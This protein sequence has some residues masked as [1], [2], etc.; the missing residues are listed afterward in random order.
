[1]SPVLENFA[2]EP[3]TTSAPL[4]LEPPQ[5]TVTGNLVVS[6]PDIAL[7]DG[8]LNRVGVLVDHLN[9]VLEAHGDDVTP[10][11]G[12][13]VQLEGK[14]VEL[15]TLRWDHDSAWLPRFTAVAPGGL[16][17]GRYIAPLDC[18]G[19]E[20][21]LA[22]Q[23]RY[24]NT[25]ADDVRVNLGWAGR[26]IGTQLSHF[27]A[28]PLRA[29]VIA[30]HDSW[31]GSTVLSLRTET[32]LLA[33]GLRG[34]SATP[35]QLG[36]DGAWQALREESVPPS[37]EMVVDLFIA[38]APEPDGASSGA[39]HL[40][41]RGF[42][43]L[44]QETVSW[45][46]EHALPINDDRLNASI[47]RHLFFNYFFAQGD[48]LDSGRPVI[49]TSRS[50]HYYVSAAFWSRDAFWW[51]FPALVL[52]D[53]VRARSVLL[54]CLRTC[55][56]RLPD[57]AL[58]LN[59][60]RMY[61]GFELDQAAAPVLAVWRY[62]RDSGDKT[63]CDEA[64]VSRLLRGFSGTIAPW[65]SEELELYATFLL[66][67]DDPTEYPYVTTCNAMVA[68]ALD[69]VAELSG[70]GVDAPERE[71]A[72]RVR[73]AIRERL[74]VESCGADQWAWAC[75]ARGVHELRDEPPLGL[76]LLSYLGLCGNDDPTYLATVR[77][78]TERNPF[79][80][81]GPHGGAGAPH[82]PYPSG[83]DLA[84]RLL[85]D[86]RDERGPL[87]ELCS[88]P[89]DH[90]LGCESWDSHTGK[91]RTGAAMASMSGLLAWT[92]WARI[93]GH[94]HWRQPLG[95]HSVVDPKHS[96]SEKPQ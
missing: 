46:D 69:A 26:W 68:A 84:S 10:F 64:D 51:T 24:R 80:F 37:E 72:E 66:P 18:Y 78:T 23:L 56:P 49:T 76:R 60:T 54:E 95:R 92:A 6:A 75:D 79:Y 63:I 73:F 14:A 38:V 65:W 71:R 50:P 53:P 31:T 83:F 85:T 8:R 1:M 42:D 62:V 35:V 29:P 5:C 20:R 16:V 52:I 13:V 90:G 48:C 61:P 86:A 21:G 81:P 36:H 44:H 9:G 57:H 34:G 94:R 67:T 32:P 39:L 11:A 7:A 59:G 19:G 43:Q 17:S 93:I 47:N 22:L 33:I 96:V 70:E 12:L 27:R 25:S 87:A 15:E 89:L 91:V 30:E 77:W 3:L 40:R 41:R 55:G 2:G 45:L 88:L 28:K 58:Y 4:L 74:R 82:F